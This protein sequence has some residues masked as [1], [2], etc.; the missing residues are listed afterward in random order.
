MTDNLSPG[1]D[2][3]AAIFSKGVGRDSS[4]FGINP[5][6]SSA[7]QDSWSGGISVEIMQMDKGE[8]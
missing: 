8:C 7:V 5:D 3:Q 1:F 6:R 2:G 4:R